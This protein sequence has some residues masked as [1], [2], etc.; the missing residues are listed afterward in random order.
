MF[1]VLSFSLYIGW[2]V[3]SSRSILH[4]FHCLFLSGC[5]FQID[6][7]SI[8]L[9]SILVSY[10]LFCARLLFSYGSIV[11]DFF[12][13]GIK[14]PGFRTLWITPGLMYYIEFLS[15]SIGQKGL[16]L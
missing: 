16:L 4:F 8:F 9:Q 1:G 6:F 5:S 12:L 7:R 15:S 3:C 2:F 11:L 13:R 14:F 10:L